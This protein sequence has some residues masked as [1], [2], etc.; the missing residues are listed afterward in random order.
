MKFAHY[1]LLLLFAP[2]LAFGQGAVA[3]K[4]TKA[5]TKHGISEYT[6]VT[7]TD[8][9]LKDFDIPSDVLTEGL[10]VRMLDR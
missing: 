6:L 5:V 1:L 8:R 3:E 10:I 9:D 2:V 4:V 7:T